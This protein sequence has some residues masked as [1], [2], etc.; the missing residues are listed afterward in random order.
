M[1]IEVRFKPGKQ[2]T[3]TVLLIF[4]LFLI[5]TLHKCQAFDWSNVPSPIKTPDPWEYLTNSF[6][7][8]MTHAEFTNLVNRVYDPFGGLKPYLTITEKQATIVTGQTNASR[9]EIVFKDPH[10]TIQTNSTVTGTASSSNSPPITITNSVSIK[11]TFRTPAEFRAVTNT[12]PDKPLDGLRVA[13]DPG[14]IGGKWADI[15]DRSTYY[16]GVGR[17]QEGDLNL[18]TAARLKKELEALGCV[19]A[20]THEKPEPVTTVR[21]E[22]LESEADLYLQKGATPPKSV[23]MSQRRK[24]K[25]LAAFLFYRGY[26][27]LARAERIKE[28]HP[29]ITIVLY[30]NASPSSA[31]HKLIH[32]NQNIFFVEGGYLKS[33]LADPHKRFRLLYKVLNDVTP[34]EMEVAR[35]I[36]SEFQKT[37]KLPPV[38][39]GDS[40]TT[41]LLDEREPY[42]VARNLG[43]NREYDGPV[44]VTEPYFMNHALTA[45]RLV[46]GDY[47]GEREIDG[48]LVQSIYR[49]YAE[50][51]KNGLLKVYGKTMK[52]N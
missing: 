4:F 32:V 8:T 43:A 38:P 26:E 36:S 21:P 35:A 28:F 18:I 42:I 30:I 17:L 15:E 45:K 29:D 16:K 3:K 2:L 7:S 12:P 20:L 40:N 34:T 52:T 19:V 27:I 24:I 25:D 48:V 33:E 10:T 37:T 22:D 14:H 50:C 41:R 5:L 49:E 1:K 23:F 44:V 47:E 51:V 6:N 46:A 9:I 31:R 13:I 39:Y 11:R